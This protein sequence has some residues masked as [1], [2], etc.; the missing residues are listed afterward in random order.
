MAK[1]KVQWPYELPRNLYV[2][3]NIEKEVGSQHVNGRVLNQEE[4]TD[5]GEVT[6]EV[7]LENTTYVAEH[8]I[9][10]DNCGYW[11]LKSRKE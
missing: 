6:G 7:T 8:R 4:D 3:P 5:T 1:I 11:F 9:S 10:F 2:S